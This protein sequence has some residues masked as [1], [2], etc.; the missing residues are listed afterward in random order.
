M[1]AACGQL[2]WLISSDSQQTHIEELLCVHLGGNK[3]YSLQLNVC[4]K[5]ILA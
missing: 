5:A 3:L 2:C 4:Q 1:T